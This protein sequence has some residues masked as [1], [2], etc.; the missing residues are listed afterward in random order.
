MT[1]HRI[2]IYGNAGSGKAT[3]ARKVASVHGSRRIVPR[4]RSSNDCLNRSSHLFA[5]TKRG[6]TSIRWLATAPC[7][8]ALRGRSGSTTS[9]FHREQ[10]GPGM[11][12]AKVPDEA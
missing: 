8:M 5:N 9:D 11:N 7:S 2:V 4:R 1:G 3:M 10:A 12:E 6:P